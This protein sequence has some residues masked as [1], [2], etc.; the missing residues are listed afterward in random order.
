MPEV[1]DGAVVSQDFP[2]FEVNEK[3]L[4]PEFL[5]WMSKT[6]WFVELCRIASEGSTNRVRLREDRFLNHEITLPPVP[7]QLR[8]IQGLNAVAAGVEDRARAAN[9]VEADLGASLK[10]AFETVTIGVPRARM[11]DVAPLVRRPVQIAPEV[12]YHELGVRSFGRG[13]FD[14][15]PL[16][17]A[18][19]TWQKLFRV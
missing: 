5:G 3:R 2:V 12:V 17:G 14:K 7:E 18:D 1:L 8:I 10:K 11:G 6:K 16:K 9:A 15:P 13:L 19:L 4:L